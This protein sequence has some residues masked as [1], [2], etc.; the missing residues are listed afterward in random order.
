ME[1]AMKLTGI[2]RWKG[3]MA[4]SGVMVRRF[5][6]C[7]LVLACITCVI[8]Q[9]GYV[10]MQ[11]LDGS[12]AYLIFMLVPIAVAAML[13][14][15]L[16]GAAVGLLGGTVLYAHACLMSIDYYELVYV[17]PVTTIVAMALCGLA[18]GLL[19]AVVLSGRVSGRR[20]V[21]FLVLACLA[22][23]CVFSVTC[24][25][26]YDWST[27]T[28][29]GEIALESSCAQAIGDTVIMAV[30]SLACLAIVEHAGG[31]VKVAGL[32][33]LFAARLLAVVLVSFAIVAMSAYWAVTTGA[34]EDSRDDMRSEAEYLLGQVQ[35]TVA[36]SGKVHEAFSDLEDTS[37]E[38]LER[39][40]QVTSDGL[41]SDILAGYTEDKDGLVIT[42]VSEHV[43]G[44]NVDRLGGEPNDTL[45]ACLDEGTLAAVERSIQ[46]GTLERIIY[47]APSVYN[48]LVHVALPD[49]FE[50]LESMLSPQVG[51]L[52]AVESDGYGI[53][54]I[55]PA[56]TV[57]ADRDAIAGWIT[58]ASLAL[59]IV[60]SALVWRLL[61]Q[62]VTRRIAAANAALA[63]ITAGDLK[64]RVKPGGA[65]EFVEL[66]A[67]I[68][69]T[70]DALQGWI[71]EAESRMDAE[72]ATAKA[73]QE[74]ALPQ[75]FPP[76][77]DIMHF[78]IYASM[79]AAKEVGGDF[80]D[81]FLIGDESGPDAG[82]LAFVMADVS[83]KGVPAALFMM[84]AKTQIRDYLEA[85][86]E[87]GEAI[88]NVNRQLVDGNEAGMFVTAWV[89]VL[90]CGSGHVDYVNAGHNPPL[91]WQSEAQGQDGSV[92]SGSWRWLTEKSGIPLGLFEDLPYMVYSVECMPGDTF[93]L[94]TDGVTEAMNVEG[95]L[96]GEDR[97]EALVNE[98]I[99][100]H[101]R[102]LVTR[103]R[104]GVAAHAVGAEQSDD[105]TI[106]ALEVGVPPE[107]KAVLVVPAD[108]DE[109]DR[110]NDFIHAELDRRLCPVRVQRLLDVAVEEL[111]VNVCSYAY[112]GQDPEIART[113]RVT[114]A[115]SVE[116]PS[117]TVELIDGGVPFDPL[118]KP[119]ASMVDEFAGDSDEFDEGL[120]ILLAK[121]IVDEMRYERIDGCNVVTLVKRW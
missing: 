105:I 52:M 41:L 40:D 67:G 102:A 117:I 100:L 28:A 34:L 66:S 99:S 94:Y 121:K 6:M 62:M 27:I 72:L 61:N 21:L 119:D 109:L 24:A 4:E 116:P 15:T 112:E 57:F 84:K 18:S 10:G 32:R 90:E 89:G 63:R 42:Y 76:Y 74:S 55:R 104:A 86:M 23:S 85:G 96:Y 37:P 82:K 91:L 19:F 22:A 3:M 30:V 69:R 80:Y 56:G 108:T 98:D 38:S 93:L 73:I 16:L 83:G 49:D 79:N 17:N 77:P 70:V 25:L 78:D 2:L 107:E 64:A 88:E 53:I 1:N 114:Q 75:V 44:T 14:G 113:V 97:L 115:I 46:D 101:P 48:D 71:A 8:T 47:L 26:G 59:L 87:L 110:V 36:Y 65:L 58:F 9:W 29:A 68:N 20:R 81:F 54:V 7:A 31:R 95:E 106:L 60:V 51:Y 43:I 12:M 118:A 13:L 45:E 33:A 92:Q 5:T 11:F 103:V 35:R 120:G 111:F 39:F 50:E